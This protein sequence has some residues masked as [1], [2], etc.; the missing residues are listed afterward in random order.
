MKINTLLCNGHGRG[1]GHGH[2]TWPWFFCFSLFLKVLG[3]FDYIETLKQAVA[4]FKQNNRNKRLFSDSVKTGFGS[5]LV[6]IE[7]KLVL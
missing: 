1:N 7:T 5:S 6:Y 4:I 2:C 3:C